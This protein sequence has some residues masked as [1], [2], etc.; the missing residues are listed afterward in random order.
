MTHPNR[1]IERPRIG[2]TLGDVAGIGPEIVAKAL[3]SGQLNNR[4]DYEVIG[5]PR[6]RRRDA[7]QWHRP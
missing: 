3:A 1:P 2:I 5:D 7:R 6:A 4:F